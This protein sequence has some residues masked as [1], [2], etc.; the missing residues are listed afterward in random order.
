MREPP[1]RWLR[2]AGGLA[3]LALTVRSLMRHRSD[4]ALQPVQWHFAAVPLLESFGLIFLSF[5]AL[6]WSWWAVVRGWRQGVGPIAAARAWSLTNLLRYRPSHGKAVDQMAA[7]AE[8]A[9]VS[10]PFAVGAALLPRLITLA[11]ASAVASGLYVLNRID[12]SPPLV[13][14]ACLTVAGSLA[15]AV[16]L[17]STDITWRISVAVHRPN[18]IRP[19]EPDAIGLAILTDVA[20]FLAQGAALRFLG[21]ALLG[22]N[23]L[24]WWVATGS[25]SAAYVVGRLL[26]VLPSGFPVREAMLVILLQGIIGPGPAMALALLWRAVLTLSEVGAAIPFLHLRSDTRDHA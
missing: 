14:A 13:L 11:G 18:A 26:P 1:S 24:S 10:I 7:V 25:L 23:D 22:L 15:G 9:G 16:L 19:I 20:G 6:T 4:F 8:R 2:A 5:I 21:I 17:T 12:A 3:I